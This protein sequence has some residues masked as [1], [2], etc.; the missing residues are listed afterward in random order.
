MY[1]LPKVQICQS[2]QLYNEVFY[3]V[4]ITN[5]IDFPNLIETRVSKLK[6]KKNKNGRKKKQNKNIKPV[7]FSR[8]LVQRSRTRISNLVC[9]IN[10]KHVFIQTKITF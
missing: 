1:R 3:N 7:V 2:S 5:P 6:D 9:C 10:N 4:Y 8:N